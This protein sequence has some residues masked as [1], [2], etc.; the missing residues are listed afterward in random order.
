M[1]DKLKSVEKR[2]DDLNRLLSDPEIISQQSEFQKYAK[3]QSD[4][5]P[6][7]QK[8]QSLQKIN[9]QL[10]ENKKIL[11]E[12]KDREL[13]EMAEEDV[14][15]LKAQKE[16]AEAALKL[17]LLPKDP[18]D[19][20]NVIVEIRAGTGGEEAALFSNDLFRM[21]SRY[22]EEKKWNVEIL[23]SSM[24]GKGGFKEVIFNILGKGVYSKLKYEGGTHRVQRVP[25]TESQGRI[26]TS[27]VTV[28]V[29]PEVEEVDIKINP[30]DIK[31]DVYRSSGPGGQSVNTTDS[32]VRLTYI[33]TGMIVTCQ[34]EKSQHKNREKAMKVLRAR[35]YDEE[36]RKQQESMAS[37]RKQQ[38]GSGDR[39]GRIRTYNYPQERITD[40]R[41][42]LTLHKLS[43]VM[44][45]DLDEIIDA[46]SL[47]FQTQA[48]KGE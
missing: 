27:A 44:E 5:A 37:E 18:R 26:H 16:K 36:Q 8:F 48:L 1:F 15:N 12:E 11:N 2:Y 29:M 24:T 7:V 45:G 28:A 31:V 46:L 10:E 13:I 21:Y 19:D 34:D 40:H 14:A 17:L 3:E 4:L 22:A 25:D 38:V 30:A 20:R 43:F 9:R 39:S 42:G 23:S 35:L 33:P 41:V 47:H 6:I 32:A